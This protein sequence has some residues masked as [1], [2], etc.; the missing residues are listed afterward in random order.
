MRDVILAVLAYLLAG[1]LTLLLA[2]RQPKE[3]SAEV[4]T[5]DMWALTLLFWWCFV[6]ELIPWP[7]VARPPVGRW[8][9]AY[10]ARHPRLG[11]RA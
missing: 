8:L 11:G 10:R 2:A 3:L 6:I 5:N 1:V 9:R 7:S 4:A